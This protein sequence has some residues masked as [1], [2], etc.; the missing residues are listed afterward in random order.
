MAAPGGGVAVASARRGSRATPSSDRDQGE[1][2]ERV[3]GL[4]RDVGHD[5][6]GLAGG[7]QVAAAERA[8]GDPAL[9]AEARELH[10]AAAGR[11]GVRLGHGDHDRF[12]EE[13]DRLD[14]PLGF[15][16]ADRRGRRGRR[17]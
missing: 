6:H 5:V 1:H 2:G 8:S 7:Q 11:E 13:R 16:G 14:R 9:V 12:G 10:R 3:V 4:E 17:R 15:R